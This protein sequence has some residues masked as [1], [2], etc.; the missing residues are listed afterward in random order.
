VAD[1]LVD[2]YERPRVKKE[3][4]A[5]ASSFFTL[6]VLL[7]NCSVAACVNRLVVAVPKVFDLAGRG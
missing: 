3:V 6:C 1:K 7:L 5:L 4:N 2:L